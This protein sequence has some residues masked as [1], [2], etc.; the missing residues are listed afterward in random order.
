MK[1][2]KKYSE[3]ESESYYHPITILWIEED[4]KEK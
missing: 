1:E 2:R 4:E 3:S